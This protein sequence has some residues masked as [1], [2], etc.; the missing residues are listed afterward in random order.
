M[1]KQMKRTPGGGRGGGRESSRNSSYSSVSNMRSTDQRVT[2]SSVLFQPY[3]AETNQGRSTPQHPIQ[4]TP[5]SRPTVN[6]GSPSQEG[7]AR[8][9]T[10]IPTHSMLSL[11]PLRSASTSS[12]AI[13]APSPPMNPIVT[14]APAISA[15]VSIDV[16]PPRTSLP[17]ILSHDLYHYPQNHSAQQSTPDSTSGFT[18]NITTN[19]VVEGRYIDDEERQVDVDRDEQ[20]GDDD[21]YNIIDDYDLMHTHRKLVRF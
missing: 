7:N 3:D 5:T 18:G 8:T 15:P 2:R 21:D 16:P 4:R 19:D 9:Q 1:A 11:G 12:L 10:P 6:A 13:G 17:S 14:S 20:N